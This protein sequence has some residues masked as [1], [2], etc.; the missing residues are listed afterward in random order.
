MALTDAARNGAAAVDAF[1]A[2]LQSLAAMTGKGGG[3]MSAE[4]LA[5]QIRRNQAPELVSAIKKATGR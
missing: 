3:A 1:V 2:S 4:D 5:D